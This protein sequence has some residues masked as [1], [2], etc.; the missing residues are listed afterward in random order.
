[1][2]AAVL[3]PDLRLEVEERPV[4]TPGHGDVLVQVSAVGVCGSDTHY[5]R[6]GRIGD[7]VVRNPLVLGHE[8]AGVIVDVGE[9]VDAARIGERVWTGHR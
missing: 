9:G 8:A 6:E 2:K 3:W 7:H 5:L 1:M 4:P